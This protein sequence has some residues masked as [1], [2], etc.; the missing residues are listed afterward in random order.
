MITDIL[1]VFWKE[2]KELYQQRTSRGGLMTWLIMVALVGVFIPL[3]SGAAW[4][5]TPVLALVW[6]WP[7][8]LG[9]V[10]IVADSFAGERERHTLETLLASRLPDQ[11][12]LLAKLLI[13]VL[14]GWS[15]EVAALIAGTITVN[16]AHPAPTGLLIYPLGWL[17]TILAVSLAAIVFICSIGALVSLRSATVRSAYQKLSLTMLAVILLPNLA[18]GMVSPGWRQALLGR[19][20]TTPVETTLWVVIAVLVVLDVGIILLANQRFQRSRLILD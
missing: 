16:L 18:L 10:W 20:A 12:I 7:P 17:A 13:A 6:I 2:W 11:A 3:Q 5:N 1:A 14:Y 8:L 9:V 19:V 4:V 15:M